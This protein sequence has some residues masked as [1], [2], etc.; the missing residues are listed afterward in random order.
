MTNC[1]RREAEK[2]Y[3][4]ITSKDNKYEFII[5][6]KGLLG[7]KYFY[8][9]SDALASKFEGKSGNLA[10]FLMDIRDSGITFL[11]PKVEGPYEALVIEHRLTTIVYVIYIKKSE[12]PSM[13][14][15]S[16][17]LDSLKNIMQ[18]SNGAYKLLASAAALF[19]TYVAA[20]PIYLSGLSSLPNKQIQKTL[21]DGY[22]NL[23]NPQ[24]NGLLL[25]RYSNNCSR[26]TF[27]DMYSPFLQRG[28][29]DSIKDVSASVGYWGVIKEKHLKGES[30]IIFT[31]DIKDS[32]TELIWTT[33]GVKS[34][35][36]VPIMSKSKDKCPV[37]YLSSGY[38]ERL[39]ADKYERIEESMREISEELVGL[40]E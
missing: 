18:L 23:P 4:S 9:C 33:Y 24:S 16:H 40:D 13:E 2:L 12:S 11:F 38:N 3:T 39:S 25:W 27:L 21:H 1:A 32:Q 34:V 36:S 35:V 14:D 22:Y 19:L 10:S 37:G 30:A 17:W 7:A 15:I 20:I 5:L 6:Y 31:E 28:A 8:K 26:R 29:F